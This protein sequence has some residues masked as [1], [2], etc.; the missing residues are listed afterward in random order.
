MRLE[1]SAFANGSAIP[2]KFTCDGEDHSPP[3]RWSGLPHDTR[4]FVLLCDD[5]D[6]PGGVWHHWAV[7]DIPAT[8][9]SLAEGAAQSAKDTD[10]KQAINDFRRTSYGGPCPLP[11]HGLHHYHFRLLALS[12]PHLSVGKR[13]A[14]RDIENEARK[15]AIAEAV[16]VGV[17]ERW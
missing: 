11:K 15:H 6:A 5:P 4:S 3:L 9:T 10:F 7:Y 2:R 1:S 16:L 13:P 17:Y 8:I 14:C 12:A